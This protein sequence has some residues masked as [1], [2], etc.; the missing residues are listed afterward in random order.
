LITGC[1]ITPDDDRAPPDASVGV[2][3]Y[4]GN[5]APGLLGIGYVRGKIEVKGGC[6]MN[7]WGNPVG[8]Y[9]YFGE[10]CPVRVG[11]DDD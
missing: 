1:A 10:T 9:E 5:I 7:Q 3:E 4:G 8:C 2:I 11:R 6:R